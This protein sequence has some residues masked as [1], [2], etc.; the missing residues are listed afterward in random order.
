CPRSESRGGGAAAPSTRP[1]TRRA[2]RRR[3]QA[4]PRGS[5]G[6]SG[7]PPRVPRG[8]PDGRGRATRFASPLRHSALLLTPFEEMGPPISSSSTALEAGLPLLDE[9][10]HP[11]LRVLRPEELRLELA[12]EREARLERQRAAG[13]TGP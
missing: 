2:S 11:L 6:A 13:L 1:R 10:R 5:R 9:R 12:L 4:Q 7:G 8:C 3:R